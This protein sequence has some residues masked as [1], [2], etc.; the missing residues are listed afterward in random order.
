MK[1]PSKEKETPTPKKKKKKRGFLYRWMHHDVR[2]DDTTPAAASSATDVSIDEDAEADEQ[3]DTDSVAASATSGSQHIT[4]KQSD[5][6]TDSTGPAH[7]TS[8]TSDEAKVDV[9]AQK[10]ARERP[11]G[12]ANGGDAPVAVA[13]KSGATNGVSAG[14][15]KPATAATAAASQPPPMPVSGSASQLDSQLAQTAS[16]VSELVDEERCRHH[17][18]RREVSSVQLLARSPLASVGSASASL[19]RSRLSVERVGVDDFRDGGMVSVHLIEGRNLIACD[20][21]G[22][23]D[24]YCKISTDTSKY[25]SAVVTK[26]LNPSWDEHFQLPFA[27][28]SQPLL[29][30]VFDKDFGKPDDPM[31]RATVDLTRLDSN[32]P[33][34]MWIPL[35]QAMS[36]D[37]HIA[38]QLMPAA[39]RVLPSRA[40]RKQMVARPKAKKDV[41]ARDGTLSVILIEAK[42]L[43]PRANN[44]TCTV[45]PHRDRTVG[46]RAR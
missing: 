26:S 34:D 3:Q 10:P 8:A 46:T 32:A 1:R 33:M 5:T 16:T 19:I 42:D 2:K 18:R 24:P 4:A 27:S 37:I 22:T 9:A 20:R 15:G 35:Q 29:I 39:D 12:G 38:V 31:G 45:V 44:G 17:F 30:R 13:P 43:P 23:S 40:L 28:I 21:G 6:F 11:T 25:K 7:A 36:G 41:F 14:S